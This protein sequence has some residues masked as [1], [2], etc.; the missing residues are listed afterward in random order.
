MA[1]MARVKGHTAAGARLAPGM[2]NGVSLALKGH[3]RPRT[4]KGPVVERQR[5][6]GVALT[7]A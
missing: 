3:G 6:G 7:T 2:A 4:L 1:K 5:W